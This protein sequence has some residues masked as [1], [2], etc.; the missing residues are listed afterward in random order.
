MP[1]QSFHLTMTVD[2]ESG[3]ALLGGFLDI[4]NLRANSVRVADQHALGKLNDANRA[5]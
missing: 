5:T 4:G 3:F 2:D 1:L